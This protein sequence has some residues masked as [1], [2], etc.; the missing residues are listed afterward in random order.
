ML[1]YKDTGPNDQN[2]CPGDWFDSMLVE[3]LRRFGCQFGF[4]RYRTLAK[5]AKI[6]REAAGN[7]A[8]INFV[9]GSNPTD[10]LTEEDLNALLDIVSVGQN[11]SL[12]VVAF[13]N[14]LF[15]P[16][17]AYVTDSN[18]QTHG[19]VG[20]A[21]FTSHAFG[22]NVESWLELGPG[23]DTAQVLST[24]ASSIQAWRTADV[25]HGAYQVRSVTDLSQLLTNKIIITN[26][27]R[28][29]AVAKSR[30]G[31]NANAAM[32]TARS[33]RWTAPVL[34]DNND[35]DQET[36]DEV[37]AD[38]VAEELSEVQVTGD[39]P[40]PVQPDPVVVHRWWKRMTRSDVM[41]KPA[42][43]HQ[44]NYVILGKAGHDID[45]KTWFREEFFAPI[46]DWEQETMRTGN[47][48]EVADVQFEVFVDAQSRGNRLV[49]IEHA[50]NRIADQNNAPTWL[51]WSNL[52][53]IIRSR[54]FTNWYLILERFEPTLF[55]LHLSRSEPD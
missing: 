33:V 36:D 19:F 50:P 26:R 29:K 21:N 40:E 22:A 32:L 31:S 17:V 6:L 34:Y 39:D 45:Q 53:E 8:P 16:K 49:R 48:K 47:V 38:S 52:T 2:S 15:H 55:R 3:G 20:S 7:G 24:I 28:K 27:A 11:C 54:D 4:F 41:R 5:Y 1:T 46:N 37:L 30:A 42:T 13:R 14:A 23:P 35:E 25:S 10:R 44:R 9:L 51:H 43:S 18:G 12:T